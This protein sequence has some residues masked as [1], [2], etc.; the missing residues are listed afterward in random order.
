MNTF[1]PGCPGC[2]QTDCPQCDGFAVVICNCNK[3]RD[4]DFDVLINGQ[5]IGTVKLGQDACN[6][7]VFITNAA[8]PWLDMD[9][10]QFDCGG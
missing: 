5:Y 10:T 8:V 7:A 4:D 1:A 3:E 2:S 6:G 9:F